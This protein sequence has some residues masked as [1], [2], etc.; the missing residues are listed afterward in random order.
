MR[1]KEE[2]VD[3]DVLFN[4]HK[5]LGRPRKEQLMS[6][7]HDLDQQV[8]AEAVLVNTCLHCH[9]VSKLIPRSIATNTGLPQRS[10]AC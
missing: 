7:K 6:E 2:V 5:T 10:T 4:L 9:N 3:K 8:T 1:G